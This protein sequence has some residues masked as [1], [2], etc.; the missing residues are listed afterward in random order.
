MVVGRDAGDQRV[1]ADA[2]AAR[3]ARLPTISEWWYVPGASISRRRRSGWDGLASSSS[4]NEVV[5]PNRL[6]STANVPD[7]RDRPARGRRDRA[8]HSWIAGQ[9]AVAEERERRHDHDVDD[10][11]RHPGLHERPEP[12]AA[13][14]HD[15]AGQPAE[16]D[17]RRELERVR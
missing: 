7:G 8:P 5:I 4:W 11:H 17:V 10:R 2:S 9:V 14:D 12:F 6:P 1:G 15:D 13:P 16:E 3:S